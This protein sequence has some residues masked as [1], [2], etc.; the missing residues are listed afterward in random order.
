MLSCP[1]LTCNWTPNL[2]GW[3]FQKNECFQGVA[4]AGRI[5]SAKY[6]FNWEARGCTGS[7]GTETRNGVEGELEGVCV[8]GCGADCGGAKEVSTGHERWACARI[9]SQET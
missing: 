9:C 3:D 5:Y 8:A 7:G 1:S 4:K 6:P 2:S